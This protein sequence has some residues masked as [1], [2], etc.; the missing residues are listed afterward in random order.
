MLPQA[1]F[2]YVTSSV[3]PRSG[4]EVEKCIEKR[5]VLNP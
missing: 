5:F 3:F 2:D 1:V 4:S